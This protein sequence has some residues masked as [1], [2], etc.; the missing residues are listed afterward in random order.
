MAKSKSKVEAYVANLKAYAH[1]Y[2]ELSDL[3]V[4]TKEIKNLPDTCDLTFIMQHLRDQGKIILYNDPDLGVLSLASGAETAW[5][6]YGVPVSGTAIDYFGKEYAW[7]SSNGTIV[8][9]NYGF[10]Q[11]NP[12]IPAF[13][14]DFYAKA[15]ATIRRTIDI[16]VYSMRTPVLLQAENDKQIASLKSLFEAYDGMMP[17][18]FASKALTEINKLSAIN[19]NTHDFTVSLWSL[20]QNVMNEALTYL[21]IPNTAIEKRERV[22]IQEVMS[23]NA[24]AVALRLST[25]KAIQQ[26]LDRFNKLKVTAPMKV[27]FADFSDVYVDGSN[28]GEDFGG[29]ADI[30]ED[31]EV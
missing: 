25:L 15:L 3:Y 26:G 7:D 27:Q 18:A 13:A 1:Y 6:P 20:F 8:Y 30:T 17:F 22:N 23:N 9:A 12:V 19:M 28:D 24:G 11:K 10:T 31:E 29:D 16:N 4:A 21:G 5:N 14:I 2:G